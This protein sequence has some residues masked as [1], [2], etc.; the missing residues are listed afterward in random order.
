MFVCFFVTWRAKGSSLRFDETHLLLIENVKVQ[1]QSSSNEKVKTFTYFKIWSKHLDLTFVLWGGKVWTQEQKRS[2]PDQAGRHR[3]YT[4]GNETQVETQVETIRAWL[5][6]IRIETDNHREGR[7][8]KQR[9]R[10]RDFKIKQETLQ[11]I[12]IWK[13]GSQDYEITIQVR[14][15]G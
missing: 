7:A 15:E 14:Q 9:K 3:L 4:L 12:T 13:Y 11:I 1:S 2:D 8:G 6:T 5:E 10:D